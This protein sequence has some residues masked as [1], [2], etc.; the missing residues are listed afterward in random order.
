M[1]QF[2]LITTM[3]SFCA[4]SDSP[5]E[6]N[7]LLPQAGCYCPELRNNV[8]DGVIGRYYSIYLIEVG[9]QVKKAQEDSV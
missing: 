8:S 4:S 3:N 6:T 5:M 1:L 9:K 2:S 7:I